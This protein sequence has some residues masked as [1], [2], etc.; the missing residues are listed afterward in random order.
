[1]E[2]PKPFVTDLIKNFPYCDYTKLVL[3][4]AFQLVISV[5]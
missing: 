3:P 4:D 1:M 2:A 5:G